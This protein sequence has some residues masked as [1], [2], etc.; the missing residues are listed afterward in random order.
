MAAFL[1]VSEGTLERTFTVAAWLREDAVAELLLDASPWGLGAALRIN[2]E[3]TAWLSDP[4]S[5]EDRSVLEAEVGDCK[6][7]QLAECL[8]AL[9]EF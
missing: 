3:W 5:E 6:S 8:C 7:Q 4:L 2:G 1:F 9:V